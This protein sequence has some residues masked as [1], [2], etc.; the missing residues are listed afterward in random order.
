[1]RTDFLNIIAKLSKIAHVQQAVYAVCRA[2]IPSRRPKIADPESYLRTLYKEKQNSCIMQ[3]QI[4]PDPAYDVQIIVPTYNA[5]SYICECVDSVLAQQTKYTYLLVIVD[6][7]STDDTMTLLQKYEVYPQIKII[8]QPNQ[9]PSAARNNGLQSINARYVSFLD[10]D[11]SLPENALET[12]ISK[13][14]GYQTDMIEGSHRYFKGDATLRIRHYEDTLSSSIH[15]S[16]FSWG[17]L[18][19]ADLWQHIGF[20]V[21]YWYED[22]IVGLVLS[23]MANK[24]ALI[25]QIIYNYRDTPTGF[26]RAYNQDKR[27]VET[28]WVSKQLLADARELGVQPSL[29]YYERFLRSCIMNTCRV[30]ILG[31]RKADCALFEAQ[32]RLREQYFQDF[33]AQG[34]KEKRIEAAFL[35]NNFTEYFLFSLFLY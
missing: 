29:Y 32:R 25:H 30:A 8:R 3:H 5:S 1:M 31:D 26:T 10:A 11:D 20:P 28:Y 6:D 18:Y 4:A 33:R 24:Q 15:F 7:G 23:P 16:S 9:G 12:L 27:R 17:K 14:D 21:D 2:I 22:M 35:S 19:K 34:Q 13:A